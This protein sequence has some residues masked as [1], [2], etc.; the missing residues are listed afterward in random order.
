M[1]ILFSGFV[2]MLLPEYDYCLGHKLFYISAGFSRTSPG[3]PSHT[4]LLL[5]LWLTTYWMLGHEN[6]ILLE[7]TI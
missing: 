2:Y 5:V 7:K 6:K 4:S 1:G 3:K